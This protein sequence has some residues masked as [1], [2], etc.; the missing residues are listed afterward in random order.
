ME[1]NKTDYT[2]FCESKK[3]PEFIRWDCGF[4]ICTSC[5]LV[6]QSEI[7]SEYPS[8]CLHLNEITKI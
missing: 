7:V 5:K 1:E 4:G 2:S 6:G 8:D 3:C